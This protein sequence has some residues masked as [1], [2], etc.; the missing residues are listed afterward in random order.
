M[1]NT[2]GIN[3]K[4]DY[5]EVGWRSMFFIIWKYIGY[6]HMSDRPVTDIAALPGNSIY[7]NDHLLAVNGNPHSE[8]SAVVLSKYFG[9][10]D[11]SI[12]LGR[13]ITRRRIGQTASAILLGFFTRNRSAK[14]LKLFV[15][16]VVYV[17]HV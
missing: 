14:P 3:L 17:K 5:Q 7:V 8:S 16:I 12:F 11:G 13:R 6:S 1:S 2:Y 4:S 15:I 9:L 10:S